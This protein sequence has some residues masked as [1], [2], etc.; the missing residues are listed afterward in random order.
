MP[1]VLVVGK[2]NSIVNWTENTIEGFRQAGCTV[3]HVSLNGGD[4]VQ[5]LHYKLREALDG[6]KIKVISETLHKKLKTFEPDLVVFMMIATNWMP[7][8]PFQV[9]REACSHATVVA[10]VGDRFSPTEGVFVKYMDRVFCTDTY[11][12][13]QV[14]EY[15]FS[16][17]A[18]YLPLALDPQM[19]HPMPVPRS[20]RI[21]YVANTTPGRAALVRSINRPLTLYGKGWSALKDTHHDVHAYR[22]PFKELP[23]MYASSRAVLNVK[24]E[25]NVVHGLSQRT[26]EP[27]GC[28]TP[29]LNDDMADIPLCFEP[30]REILVY[31]SLDELC[32]LHDRLTTDAAYAQKIGQAG[33]QRVMAE[34]TYSHRARTMLGYL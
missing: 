12:M 15:G 29:L 19:F 16:A 25:N 5:S 17:P 7:E 11:F 8:E 31:H 34:H 20:D 28:M 23:R 27:Y 13:Q 2:S 3:E 1:K 30:G 32:E 26:F 33:Y 6:S 22:L 14:Q 9:A 4:W 18:S 24:H 10:W 21:V